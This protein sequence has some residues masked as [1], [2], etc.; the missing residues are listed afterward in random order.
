MTIIPKIEPVSEN[1]I[2]YENVWK[3]VNLNIISGV[4][5]NLSS[6]TD[7]TNPTGYFTGFTDSDGSYQI[8]SLTSGEFNDL[9]GRTSGFTNHINFVNQFVTT[10]FL[11]NKNGD[12]KHLDTTIEV[13]VNTTQDGLWADSAGTI[14]G[15]SLKFNKDQ[16][17]IDRH[18]G[19]TLFKTDFAA[20]KFHEHSMADV[21]DWTTVSG[22]LY[23][24]FSK[25]KHPH[26]LNDISD[27]TTVSGSNLSKLWSDFYKHIVDM[28]LHRW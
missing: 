8:Y 1:E 3:T 23:N 13:R 26:K 6:F 28:S 14:P 16:F 2:I 11:A 10:Q 20:P 27:W 4:V 9:S 7:F 19:L 17:R 18:Q 12:L 5:G 22:E 24:Y 25:L 21:K 15:L